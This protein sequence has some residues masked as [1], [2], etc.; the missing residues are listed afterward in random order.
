VVG[1][2]AAADTIRTIAG[3]AGGVQDHPIAVV[4]IDPDGI[5][6]REKKAFDVLRGSHIVF[7]KST[8]A[9][10]QRQ[11][12]DLLDDSA[13]LTVGDAP[14]F[15]ARGGMLGLV[16]SGSRLALEANPDQIQSAGVQ[17]SAKVL[18]L[19]RIRRSRRS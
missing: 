4:R 8:D 14:D 10:V 12:F 17:V 7:L 5:E 11:V 16:R 19:A 18:K 9:D 3:A 2:D 1:S 15:A 13:V 6:R